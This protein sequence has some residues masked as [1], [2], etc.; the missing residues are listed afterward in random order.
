[1]KMKSGVPECASEPT[2]M[3][4]NDNR[5]THNDFTSERERDATPHEAAELQLSTSE[6]AA[7]NDMAEQPEPCFPLFPKLPPEIR[8][9]IWELSM[10][11]PRIVRI[12]HDPRDM[13]TVEL[14]EI[15][16]EAGCNPWWRARAVAGPVPVLLHVNKE[17]RSFMGQYYKL[18]FGNQTQ[19][20]PIY[21]D[22]ARDTLLLDSAKSIRA[23]YGQKMSGYLSDKVELKH[24]DAT[25]HQV[26]RIALR[27]QMTWGYVNSM[28]ILHKYPNLDQVSV[29]SNWPSFHTQHHFENMKR[30]IQKRWSEAGSQI[31]QI[32]Y[33]KEDEFRRKFATSCE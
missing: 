30:E 7:E 3:P 15:K 20:R 32:E 2:S 12:E 16:L 22:A 21:F 9:K 5:I 14:E 11:E 13:S 33:F 8:N 4:C 18:F 6:Q 23:F 1:M 19:G 31:P 25:E 17:A 10:P 29:C 24:M 27:S 26:R 28:Q